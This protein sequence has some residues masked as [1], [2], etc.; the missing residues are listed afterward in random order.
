M[1]TYKREHAWINK[2][3]KSGVSRDELRESVGMFSNKNK[4]KVMAQKGLTEEAYKK[5][6]GFLANV[7]SILCDTPSGARSAAS[8]RS[9]AFQSKQTSETKKFIRERYGSYEKY[10]RMKK[11]TE[12]LKKQEAYDYFHGAEYTTWGKE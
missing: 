6:Y 1:S 12:R 4:S 7:Y 3:L 9:D 8:K 5:R 10:G 2:K 11:E